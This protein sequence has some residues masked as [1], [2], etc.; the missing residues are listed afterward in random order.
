MSE[1]DHFKRSINLSEFAASR[2]YARDERESGKSVCMMR[3]PDGDKIAITQAEDTGFWLYCSNRDARD[4][5]TIIDF[6]QWREGGTLGEVRKILR[7]WLGGST[8][9]KIPPAVFAPSLL[10]MKR[11]RAAVMLAWES[12]RFQAA[13]PYLMGRGLGPDLL[14]LPRFSGCCRADNRGNVL[15][16]HYDKGGL[17]GFEI[18][19]KNFTGFAAG[20]VKGLWFS[21][22]RPSDWSL[23]LAESAIDA[24]SFHILNPDEATRYMSTGGTMNAQQPALIR[25]AMERM[26]PGA[27]VLLAFDSDEGGEKLAEEVRNVAPSGVELRRALPPV[28]TGKD[29][30][31]ALKSTLRLA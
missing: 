15:F 5:G 28:G 25:G 20:G 4:N 11:D 6:V 8:R 17:C 16:P 21:Q 13:V 18:K 22:C 12:A 27:V 10:P 30:N 26:P 9:P 3:H 1:L 14:N 19:N 24:L 23:V 2:G 31:D 29:W 7:D